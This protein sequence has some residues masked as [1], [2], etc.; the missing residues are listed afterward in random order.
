MRTWEDLA[1][2]DRFWEDLRDA[3]TRALLLDYDGTLA[4]FVRE[5][6]RA[7][8]WPGVQ[9]LL[10][11]LLGR[12][13]RG[14][15]RLAFVTGRSARDLATILDLPGPVEIWGSHGAERL[16]VDGRLE[17]VAVSLTQAEGMREARRL[18]EK[19]GYGGQ[20][21]KKPGCLALHWRWL[22]D[23]TRQTMRRAV[24]PAWEAI[25]AKRRL[26]LHA[27]D[28]G[29]ELRL[30]GLTKA[31]AVRA[32]REETGGGARIVYLGDDLTDEDAFREVGDAG[33]GVLVRREP[34][35]TQA[36]VWLRPPEEL[37]AFLS[38]WIERI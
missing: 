24:E 10:A 29:I 17:P 7:R 22:P 9:G 28:G 20:C 3:G 4:P 13:K 19:L 14:R 34:R 31:R 1:A 32:V 38:A 36:G 33:L 16:G 23:E 12:A 30:P 2:D 37:T 27:F 15:E 25:A 8:P 6:E 11:A 21:E 5:R 26:A 35:P 18:A